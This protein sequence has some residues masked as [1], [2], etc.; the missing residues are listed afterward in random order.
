MRWNFL[1]VLFSIL[2]TAFAGELATTA[3]SPPKDAAPAE[4]PGAEADPATVGTVFPPPKVGALIESGRVLAAG[5]TVEEARAK[6]GR[7]KS[8]KSTK[9]TTGTEVRLAYRGLDVIYFK[10]ETEMLQSVIVTGPNH[11]AAGG[12]TVGTPVAQVLKQLGPPQFK[13]PAKKGVST[14]D[15]GDVGKHKPAPGAAATAT[16]VRFHVRG[17]KVA[18]IEWV[19]YTP[20]R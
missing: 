2:S 14:L 19:F 12:L 4:A 20:E 1:F 6:L 17:K 15:Y 8:E 3:V 5:L 11:K 7:P 10:G 13:G 16:F 18:K 9:R